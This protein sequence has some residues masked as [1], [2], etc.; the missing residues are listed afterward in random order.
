MFREWLWQ[1]R[2]T[3]QRDTLDRG[4]QPFVC[5]SLFILVLYELACCVLCH[6]SRFFSCC[7]CM[8]GHKGDGRHLWVFFS[9]TMEDDG[10]VKLSSFCQGLGC[11]Q[12]LVFMMTNGAITCLRRAFQTFLVSSK[13]YTH[14]CNALY[15]VTNPFCSGVRVTVSLLWCNTVSFSFAIFLLLIQMQ[16]CYCFMHD[17]WMQ[18]AWSWGSLFSGLGFFFFSFTL[19]AAPIFVF[20]ELLSSRE[21]FHVARCG[22]HGFLNSFSFFPFYYLSHKG[23]GFFFIHDATSVFFHGLVFLFLFFFLVSCVFEMDCRCKLCNEQ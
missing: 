9:F 23:M 11:F 14:I 21:G 13:F 4:S 2:K 20:I 1:R 10:C 16:F 22:V 15:M 19:H 5:F 7:A 17:L 3:L 6:V 18:S 8:Y 12:F